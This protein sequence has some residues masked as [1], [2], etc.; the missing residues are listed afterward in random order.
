MEGGVDLVDLIAHQP[1]VEPATFRS[2][3]QPLHHQDNLTGSH[4][5]VSSNGVFV[6]RCQHIVAASLTSVKNCVVTA[7]STQLLVKLARARVICVTPQCSRCQ[8][9][10][11]SLSAVSLSLQSSVVSSTTRVELLTDRVD[12]PG[13]RRFICLRQCPQCCTTLFCR[14]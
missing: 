3:V 10:V 1:G 4:R 6:C 9:V 2:R 5:G 13:G 7:T 8:L 14:C 11:R 12:P